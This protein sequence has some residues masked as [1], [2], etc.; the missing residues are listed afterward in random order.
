MINVILFCLLIEG[1][2]S[3]W[4]RVRGYCDRRVSNFDLMA[5]LVGVLLAVVMQIDLLGSLSYS[6][7]WWGAPGWVEYV[8]FIL[9]GIAMGRG[10]SLLYDLWHKPWYFTFRVEQNKSRKEASK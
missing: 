1:I 7:F 5:V 6:D 8:F 3:G 9:T 10:A 2:V 4:Q